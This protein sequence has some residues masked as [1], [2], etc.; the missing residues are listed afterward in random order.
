MIIKR[1]RN[2]FG[3]DLNRFTNRVCFNTD[4]AAGGAGGGGTPAPAAGGDG[5]TPAAG[6]SN[7]GVS[8]SVNDPTVSAGGD[9]NAINADPAAKGGD[10][11]KTPDPKAADPAQ[12]D[13]AKLFG[14]HFK[15]PALQQFKTPEDVAKAYLETKKLVGSKPLKIPGADATEDERKAFNEQ[16]RAAMVPA[17][18]KAYGFKKPEGLP[19]EMEQLFS[20]EGL[21]AFA[22]TAHKLGLTKEQAE[23]LIAF[24]KARN[25]AVIKSAGEGAQAREASFMEGFKKQHGA[26]AE[27]VLDTSVGLISDVASK[28]DADTIAGAT[29]GQRMAFANVLHK[30]AQKYIGEDNLPGKG[31]SPAGKSVGELKQEL[32]ATIAS[33]SYRD[34][35]SPD[36]ATTQ[37]KAKQLSEQIALASKKR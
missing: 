2:K 24:D 31:G 13:M 17:D 22:E 26:N 3:L 9:N 32:N 15:D 21:G 30:L 28:E 37:A 11:G 36:H 5:G 35:F 7:P 29:E 34:Q 12:P 8:V 19:P 20:E 33:P 10:A 27:K 25:E 4:P 23:G 1:R 16:Y 18:P 14:E 6:G